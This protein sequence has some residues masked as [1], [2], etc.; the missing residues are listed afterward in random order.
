MSQSP[1]V[2]KKYTQLEDTKNK[3]WKT[4]RPTPYQN[5]K[6]KAVKNFNSYQKNLSVEQTLNMC[7]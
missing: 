5:K 1:R 4:K 7:H 2:E 3:K 6:I